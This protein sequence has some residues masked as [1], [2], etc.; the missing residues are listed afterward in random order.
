MK[1]YRVTYSVAEKWFKEAAE[2]GHDGAQASLATIYYEGLLG[3]KDFNKAFD[4]YMKSA[5]QGNSG[6]QNYLGVMYMAG[7]GIEQN[8]VI[9]Y[10]W[11]KLAAEQGRESAKKL[12]AHI[13]KKLTLEE[14]S[15]SEV[16][17][18]EYKKTYSK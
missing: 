12:K 2:K 18:K 6:A 16:L 13:E 17:F 1:V 15:E 5:R 11:A 3:E 14:K 4:W 9:A 7:Q 10:A 8:N